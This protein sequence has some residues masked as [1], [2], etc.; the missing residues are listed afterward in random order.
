MR[1]NNQILEDLIDSNLLKIDT[2]RKLKEWIR[3]VIYNLLNSKDI[4]TK[5]LYTLQLLYNKV[6]DKIITLI[7]K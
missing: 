5:Q 6:S 2:A 4:N 3:I 1:D 7:N